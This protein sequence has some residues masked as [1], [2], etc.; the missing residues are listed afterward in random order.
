MSTV[1]VLNRPT[2]STW[3]DTASLRSGSVLCTLI[4]AY[5]IRK[6]FGG[7]LSA[8]RSAGGPPKETS[9]RVPRNTL[10]RSMI[11]EAAL[12]LIDTAGLQAVT[13]PNVAWQLGVG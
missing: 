9:K 10:S 8:Q 5:E 3:D 2:R 12:D 13:M 4:L 11:V 6:R 7:K 1:P